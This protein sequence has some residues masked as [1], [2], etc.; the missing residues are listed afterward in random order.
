MSNNAISVS[1]MQTKSTLNPSLSLALLLNA[2][3]TSIRS[4]R[5]D[6]SAHNKIPGT[7]KISHHTCHQ[8]TYSCNIPITYG[9]EVYDTVRKIIEK[10]A[11]RVRVVMNKKGVTLTDNEKVKDTVPKI[12]CLEARTCLEVF[13]PCL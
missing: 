10:Q 7:S 2:S 6:R 12:T 9:R 5:A 1:T 3:T 11:S 4:A 8:S 13:K